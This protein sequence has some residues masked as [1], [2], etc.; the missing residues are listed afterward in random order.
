M[1]SP[2]TTPP[3]DNSQFRKQLKQQLLHVLIEHNSASFHQLCTHAGGAFP[4]DVTDML[5]ELCDEGEVQ[6]SGQEYQVNAKSGTPKLVGLDFEDIL[7]LPQAHPLDFDWRFTPGG[8][9]SLISYIEKY[10]TVNASIALLGAPTLFSPLSTRRP[11]TFL[12]DK[13][14]ALTATFQAAFSRGRVI[15]SDLREAVVW[16]SDL[17][18]LV[19]ADPPWYPDY[20]DAFMT[21]SKEL[22][23]MGGFLFMSVLPW[24]TRPTAVADRRHVIVD[25]FNF[26]FDLCEIVPNA[27]EYLSPEFEQASLERS[28][29]FL[30][31]WRRGDLFIFRQVGSGEEADRVG[32]VDALAWHRYVIGRAQI[33]V[34]DGVGTSQFDFE[35]VGTDEGILPSVSR[36]SVLRQRVNVWTSGNLAFR[37]TRPEIVRNC[38]E[39]L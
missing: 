25:A 15:T 32:D 26:G 7:P 12:F 3:F 17:F 30:P 10:T 31:D 33:Q 13:N 29:I 9:V 36:R 18:D 2:D 4:T 39:H 6:C 8:G 11:N 35:P 23:R 37:T 34:V 5:K 38:L 16:T 21:R 19:L 27:L 28:G 20:Y 1:N 22:L 14:P 24:L